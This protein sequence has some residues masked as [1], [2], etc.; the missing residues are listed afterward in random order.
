MSDPTVS[1][2][3]ETESQPAPY[4]KIAATG[5]ISRLLPG[6]RSEIYLGEDHLLLA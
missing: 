5:W 2:E 4:R 6:A 1:R 3:R